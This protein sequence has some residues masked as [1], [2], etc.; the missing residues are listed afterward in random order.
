VTGTI[1]VFGASRTKPTDARYAEAVTC[2]RL[3]AEAGFD[4]ATGGYAGTMEAVARGATLAGA[5]AYGIT[6]PAVFADR[7]SANAFITHERPEP[8]IISRIG[9]LISSTAGSIALWGSIGTA[10][11]LIAAWNV[12]YVAQF[13]DTPRKPVVAVGEPWAT[14][15]PALERGL[16]TETD[17]VELVDSVEAAVERIATLLR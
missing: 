5:K 8:D 13:S 15:V 10:A 1:A 17:L 11:E 16:D 9:T 7:S 2:G 12:A 3:L 14:I 6:A 4:V